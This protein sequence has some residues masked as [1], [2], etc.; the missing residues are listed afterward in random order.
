[1]R[2]NSQK[3]VE[4]EE[5]R[6]KDLQEKS[7]KAAEKKKKELLAR[8][9]RDLLAAREEE[10]E[11]KKKVDEALSLKAQLEKRTADLQ[12]QARTAAREAKKAKALENAIAVAARQARR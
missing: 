8:Y 6:K 3:A 5:K 9:E 12:V 1:L 4:A 2:D 10:E 11:A 7:R